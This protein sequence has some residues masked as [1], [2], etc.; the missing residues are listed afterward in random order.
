MANGIYCIEGDWAS[1]KAPGRDVRPVLDAL[2]AWDGTPYEHHGV[3]TKAELE[4]RLDG[5]VRRRSFGLGYLATHGTTRTIH[6]GRDSLALVELGDLLEG[7]ATGRVLFL[8]GC[9]VLTAAGTVLEEFC[10]R[11]GLGAI[12]GYTH[13][14]DFIEAMAF[15]LLVLRELGHSTRM[16]DAYARLNGRHEQWATQLGFR[17][18]TPTWS[19]PSPR[20]GRPPKSDA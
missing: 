5:G 16:K 7:R 11:T 9:G 19:S 12:A 4:H 13:Q 3:G 6:L 1:K 8:G 17:M 10:G 20:R 2:S 18:A 14:V 15:E